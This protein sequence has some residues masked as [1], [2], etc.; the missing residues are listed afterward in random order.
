MAVAGALS[1]ADAATDLTA[2]SAV[3]VP[4]IVIAHRPQSSGLYIGSPSIAVLP[5]GVYLA[6]HDL[7]GPKSDEHDCAS[8]FVYRSTDRGL[9]WS[10]SSRVSCAFWSG[11]FVH[12]GAVYLM[13]TEK[14]HGRI[15]I[16]R[17]ADGG[18]SW[19]EPADARAGRLTENGEYHTAPM[20]VVE[21]DGRLWRAFE[22]AMGGD[23][24]GRRYRAFMMSVPVDADLLDAGS[25][26]KSNYVGRDPSWL[27]GEFNAWLEGNAVV[28]R[29]GRVVNILRVDTPGLPE[30]AAMLEISADGTQAAFDPER[31][32][33]DFP[34][35]A[36]KF[37]LRF[38]PGSGNYWSLATVA[39]ETNHD[40]KPA[41]IRN[42]L[43][44]V[45]SRDLRNWEVRSVLLRHRDVERHG[46]QYADWLLDGDDM[47][48]VVRT[49]YEDG[50]GGA[51]NNHDANF[52]TFHRFKDFRSLTDFRAPHE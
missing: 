26:T 14:H 34:G 20:P 47:I 3:G 19:T 37:T 23:Q 12:R 38:D 36:K 39:S 13:G 1:D 48:A 44:L 33:I 21:H 4:G 31:G 7:F 43:C 6:S 30:K 40:R 11:L 49:A 51:H 18:R 5:D 25:W 28:T 22:D 2:N 10:E 24:W 16:R 35:G 32:F 15:V 42:T 27:G 50:L 46:F 29:A 8:T 41:S 17:S 45:R 9:S 52:L